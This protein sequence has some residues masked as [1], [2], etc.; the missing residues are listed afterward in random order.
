MIPALIYSHEYC[1]DEWFDSGRSINSLDLDCLL[2][3]LK[4]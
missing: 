1:A 2:D 4:L 3:S